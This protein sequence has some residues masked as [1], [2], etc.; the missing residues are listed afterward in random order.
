MTDRLQPEQVIIDRRFLRAR[1]ETLQQLAISARQMAG[2]LRLNSTAAL[3]L[4]GLARH[5]DEVSTLIYSAS[6]HKPR[7]IQK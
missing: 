3:A 5:I 4:D 7:E 6:E 1:A 2:E